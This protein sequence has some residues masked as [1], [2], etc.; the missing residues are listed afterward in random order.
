MEIK[1]KKHLFI[2]V[3]LFFFELSQ[4]PGSFSTH[5]NKTSYFQVDAAVYNQVVRGKYDNKKKVYCAFWKK[6]NKEK[7]ERQ[8]R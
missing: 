1:A 2:K 5:L 4:F 6:K 7:K 8:P 3:A